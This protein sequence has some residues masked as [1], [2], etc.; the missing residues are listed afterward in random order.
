MEVESN[1]KRVGISENPVPT[2]QRL[3]WENKHKSCKLL[4]ENNR[5]YSFKNKLIAQCDFFLG[6]GGGGT[7]KKCKQMGH[8]DQHQALSWS[9]YCRKYERIC[10]EAVDTSASIYKQHSSPLVIIQYQWVEAM[11]K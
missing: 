4:F 2:I 7:S 10:K 11:K 6:G 1:Q 9:V 3:D 5:Y 8:I